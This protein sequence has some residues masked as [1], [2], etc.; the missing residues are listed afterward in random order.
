MSFSDST[1]SIH[2]PLFRSFTLGSLSPCFV[3]PFPLPPKIPPSANVGPFLWFAFPIPLDQSIG[4]FCV[5]SHATLYDFLFFPVFILALGPVGPPL[6]PFQLR[7]ALLRLASIS[8]PLPNSRNQRCLESKVGPW[9]LPSPPLLAPRSNSLLPVARFTSP[10]TRTRPP[11][12]SAMGACP[13]W[14]RGS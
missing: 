8:T 14:V 2:L 1:Y 11:T 12:P 6:P 5:L 4:L 9:D 7:D 3:H 10:A 13:G